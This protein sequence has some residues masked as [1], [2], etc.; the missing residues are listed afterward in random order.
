MCNIVEDTKIADMQ[1]EFFLREICPRTQL[2]S[3]G[4]LAHQNAEIKWI[5]DRS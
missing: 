1:F 3:T 2:W 4:K 5:I